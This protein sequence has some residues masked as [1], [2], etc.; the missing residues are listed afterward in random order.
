VAGLVLE[1]LADRLDPVGGTVSIWCGPPGRAPAFER[2]GA[3][4]HYAASTMK[5]PLL[6]ATYRLADSGQLDLDERVTVHTQFASALDGSPYEM[7][8]EYDSDDEPWTLVGQEASFRWLARRMVV[9]SS[10]L[11]TNL[12][13]ER[14]GMDPVGQAWRICGATRSVTVRGIE[15]YTAE[16]AGLSNLVTAADLAAVLGA[17]ATGVPVRPASCAEML[18]MLADNEN[19]ANVPA[20]L[21][22]GTYVAHKDGWVEGIAHD[23]ALVRPT[24]APPYVLVVCTSTELSEDAGWELIADIARCSWADRHAMGP[25]VAQLGEP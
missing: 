22:P 13:L 21:P 6:L 23:A 1:T 16:R 14:V 20:G 7:S 19:Q 3:S 5:L 15:D 10:N 17:I 11:A 18:A 4:T 25:G 12:I 9:R 2:L 24:D 8:R